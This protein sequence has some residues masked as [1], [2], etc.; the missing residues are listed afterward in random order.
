MYLELFALT[1]L[2]K[3]RCKPLW[4]ILRCIS[5]S[6]KYLLKSWI[7]YFIIYWYNHMT[8]I[9]WIIQ[10]IQ[11]VLWHRNDFFTSYINLKK[12]IQ[13]IL[14]VLSLSYTGGFQRFLSEINRRRQIT[15][16]SHLRK[17]IHEH[18]TC[19]VLFLHPMTCMQSE[20]RRSSGAGLSLVI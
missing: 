20:Y 2:K 5:M 9:P 3:E 14:M 19:S 8:R 17:T 13:M 4:P 15:I 10:R 12:T 18:R 7:V 1:S 6:E 11:D 16:V